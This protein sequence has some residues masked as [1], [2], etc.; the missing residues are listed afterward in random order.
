MAW[1]SPRTWVALEVVSASIMNTHL[2]DQLNALRAKGPIIQ[3]GTVGSVVISAGVKAYLPILFDA[4]ITRWD[5]V[6]DASGSIVIDVWKEV[7]ASF[8][9]TVADSIAGSEKPTLSAAQKAQDTSLGTWTTSVSVGDVLGIN[10]ESC[11]GIHA[12][13]LS[14]GLDPR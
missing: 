14:L 13:W 1:S 12:A 2:R 4:T 9:P 10:V 8:P 11:S 6:A 7:W 5:L 3:I